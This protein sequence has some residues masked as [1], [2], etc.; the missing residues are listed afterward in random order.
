MKMENGHQIEFGCLTSLSIG[1]TYNIAVRPEKISLSRNPSEAASIKGTVELVTYAGG[2]TQYVV[3]AL[4][5]D[6][7]IQMQN[8]STR[9]GLHS[10]GDEIYV[11]WEAENSLVL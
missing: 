11:G 6:W 3:R 10:M 4:D 7:T 1:N 5:M 9:H 2:I 8:V